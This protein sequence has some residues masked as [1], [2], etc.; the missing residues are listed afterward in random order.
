MKEI[1]SLSEQV[2]RWFGKMVILDENVV[3]NEPYTE[4]EIIALG[5]AAKNLKKRMSKKKP[6]SSN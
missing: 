3:L 5:T 4:P 6:V 1:V 2:D